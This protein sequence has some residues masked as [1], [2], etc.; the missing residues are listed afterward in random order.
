ML[1]AFLARM[2]ASELNEA[3]L[4][5]RLKL[6]AA[7]IPTLV[8]AAFALFIG[9]RYE[10]FEQGAPALLAFSAVAGAV[11]LA[12]AVWAAATLAALAMN[13]F[14]ARVLASVNGEMPDVIFRTFGGG[15]A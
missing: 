5:R 8:V 4:A 2:A 1:Y 13:L 6:F 12:A 14:R 7:A 15:S 9:F 10:R 3:S 11:Q